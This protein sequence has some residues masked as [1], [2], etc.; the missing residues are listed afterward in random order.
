MAGKCRFSVV[1]ATYNRAELLPHA[2]ESVVR[3]TFPDW[4]LVV[5]DDGSTD[6]TREAVGSVADPRIRY[7]ALPEN[8]GATEARNRGVA[9][10]RGDWVLVW[11]SDDELAPHALET[12][13]SAIIKNPDADIVSAP[14][15][16]MRKGRE[17]PWARRPEGYITLE[18]ILCKYLPNNEKIRAARREL[19]RATPYRSRNLDFMVNGY[20]AASARWYHLAEPLGTL[21]I[22]G[23]GSLTHARRRHDPERSADR[24]P[25]LASYLE[26][27]KE[28]LTRTC[29]R[30]YG[31]YAYGA[32]IGYNHRG[33]ARQARAWSMEA[34]RHSP[35]LRHIAAFLFIRLRS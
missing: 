20:L 10:A 27:F 15:V 35:S 8:R 7:I 29:P 17:E 19:M 14:A 11:D 4:E 26:T 33:D 3:Q 22:A 31:A 32:A 5:V 9:E 1:I 16:P 13:A 34:V 12:L 28:P 24:A 21:R 23:S 18:Q 25:H 30:R 2:I 6:A